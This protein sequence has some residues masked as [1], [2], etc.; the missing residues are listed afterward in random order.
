[1]TVSGRE[2]RRVLLL[3]LALAVLTSVPYWIGWLAADD[4]QHFSGFLFGVEDGH[5]YTGKM[6]LG[7][8]GRWDFYLFYTVEAHD[9]A[10]LLF[11][12]YIIPGQ[13]AGLLLAETDPAMTGLLVGLYHLLRIAFG[14]ALVAV[15][16]RFAAEFLNS[17]RLRF[18]ALILAALGGGLGWAL[19]LVGETPPEFYIPEGFTF[20]ILLSLPHLALARV[21]LLGGLLALFAALRGSWRWALVAGLCW[22]LMGLAVPFYLA[23]IYAALAAWKLAAWLLGHRFPAQLAWRAALA[24]LTTLPLFVYN[25]LVFTANPAFARWSAQNQLPSPPPLHYALAYL[26]LA[27]LALPG[28]AL[29][30]RRA[31][32]D[33]RCALLIGW[34]L[35]VPLLVYLPVNVQRRLA[36]AVIVPLSALAALGLARLVRRL[37]AAGARRA[38]TAAAVGALSLSSLA[39]LLLALLAAASRAEPV[40]VP[41][42]LVRAFDWLNA[43]A[44]PGAVVFAAFRT[45]NRL[46]AYTHLRAFVG[47]GP[48]T[49]DAVAKTAQAEAFF[50]GALSPAE[51]AALLA[52]QRVGYIVYG[53]SERRLAPDA[54]APP[55]W[56]AGLVALYDS[57]GVAIYAVPR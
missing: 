52:G 5:S 19:L 28:G 31:Q 54:P 27:L 38:A 55:A 23:V 12:P 46:P 32:R 10:P 9:S 29:A 30:A 2:W 36:E 4:A 44:E 42:G 13:V 34:P 17:P 3:A 21:A 7:A 48:E 14:A 1:M 22:L 8:Q 18:L 24:A 15:T 35:V 33:A 41:G 39:L 56:A 11:L 37:P 25:A 40:F 16:Y 26:P 51:Q 49:L 53:P 6:R 20:Q 50:R 47:H 45:G 43:H 57:D